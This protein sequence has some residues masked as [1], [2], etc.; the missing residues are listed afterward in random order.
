MVLH[1]GPTKIG[2]NIMR[3]TNEEIVYEW[4]ASIV[5]LAWSPRSVTRRGG[6]SRDPINGTIVMSPFTDDE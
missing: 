2:R 6:T 1:D 4:T 3:F 5:T